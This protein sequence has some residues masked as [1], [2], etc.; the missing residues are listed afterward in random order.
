MHSSARGTV[1]SAESPAIGTW[2]HL[3]VF[4]GQR[5]TGKSVHMCDRALELAI[6][7]HG[8]LVLGHSLGARLPEKLPKELGGEKLPLEYHATIARLEKGLR[9]HPARWHI[10]SPPLA[11]EFPGHVKDGIAETADDLLRFAVRLSSSLRLCA[12]RKE[13]PVTGRLVRDPSRLKF[14]GLPCTPIIVCIDE[15]IAVEGA[16]SSKT[17][18]ESRAFLQFLYSLRHMHIALLWCLQDPNARSYQTIAQATLLHVHHVKH[19]WATNAIQAAGA[20]ESEIDRIEALKGYES[21]T[22]EISAP[23]R[24]K[25][26]GVE[27]GPITDEEKKPLPENETPTETD[28]AK[29][30]I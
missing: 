23:K 13:H 19:Q 30:S 11:G 21:V 28:R 27:P 24:V 6:K 5:G 16:A 9:R 15:G 12:Y 25:I 2:D 17:K 14:T 22:I 1:A 10:L 20:D 4:L 8:A 3:E 26:D 18:E 29:A 7:A